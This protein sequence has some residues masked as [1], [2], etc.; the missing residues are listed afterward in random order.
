MDRIESKKPQIVT[1]M[2]HYCNYSWNL[3]KEL[4]LKGFSN[5][6]SNSK[7]NHKI[8]SSKQQMLSG[9]E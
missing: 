9:K 6:R 2:K 8:S 5:S 3:K 7:E 4:H 1:T